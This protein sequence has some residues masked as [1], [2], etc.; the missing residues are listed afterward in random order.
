[1]QLVPVDDD[2]HFDDL[3]TILDTNGKTSKMRKGLTRVVEEG[4]K[5]IFDDPTTCRET[6]S[7]YPLSH[8]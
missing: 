3:L 4:Y 1:M 2:A 6:I 7:H 8:K 5:I